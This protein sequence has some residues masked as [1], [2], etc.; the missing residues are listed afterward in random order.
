MGR[1]PDWFDKMRARGICY[2][3]RR[4]MRDDDPRRQHRECEREITAGRRYAEVRQ[5][6]PA[7]A[8]R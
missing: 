4:P 7:L 3:C 8:D 6:P 5:S 2:I 1:N